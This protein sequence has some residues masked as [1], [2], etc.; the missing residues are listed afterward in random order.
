MRP[1]KLRKTAKRRG[2][3]MLAALIFVV[4]FM[5]L[6]VG[7]MSMSSSNAIAASNL[8]SANLARSTAESGIE[9]LRYWMNEVTIPG[10]LTKAQLYE[11]TVTELKD[12]LDARNIAAEFDEAGSL[13]IG[14]VALDDGSN[15]SFSA[16]LSLGDS[17]GVNIRITGSAKELSRTLQSAFTFGF[18]SETGRYLGF[19]FGVA[20][21]G[22]LS[23]GNLLLDGVNASVE[24]D[25]YIESLSTTNALDIKNAQIAGDVKIVNPAAIVDMSGGQSSIGG[26]Q[27]T[28]AIDNHVQVGVPAA[29]FPIPNPEHFEQYVNG[30][31]IDSSNI[32]I[33]SNNATLENVRIA[34]GTNPRFTG[35]TIVKGVMYIEQP[36]VVEF[37]G[38]AQI[39]GL[40]VGDGDMHDNSQTNQINF[41]GTV[42][43]QS[44]GQ[45]PSDTRYDGLRN[46]TGTFLMAPGFGVSFGGNFGVLNGCIAANGVRTYGNAGGE[47]GGSIINYSTTP[48]DLSGDD[49]LFNKSGITDVP[50]GFTL[51]STNSWS[52]NYAASSYSEVVCG[53]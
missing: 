34:A 46:E 13:C 30:I 8:Q 17:Q 50:S 44:V 49:L 51:T 12:I 41:T 48:M 19:D 7:M 2:I 37:G 24:A 23:L 28:A 3:A 22:P 21:K 10:T 39:T 33:Y 25:V 36:N 26:E 43:S 45:L 42:V 35:N 32:G 47:I 1:I 31:T 16:V 6:A 29:D 38:N 52:I 14:P 53:M 11:H 5:A 20:T 9:M 15:K 27:G 4:V 40:I 18:H